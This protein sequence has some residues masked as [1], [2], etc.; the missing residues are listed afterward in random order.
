MSVVGDSSEAE[1][2]HPLP[3]P[4]EAMRWGLPIAM[5]CL[6]LLLLLQLQ[7]LQQLRNSAPPAH[8]SCGMLQE[9]R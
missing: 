5:I 7:L 6:L 9:S 4:P 2:P 3:R 8:L 1:L